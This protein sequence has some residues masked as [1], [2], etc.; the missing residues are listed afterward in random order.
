MRVIWSRFR[1]MRRSLGY[2]L[3]EIHWVYRLLWLLRGVMV[4][5][6]LICLSHPAQEIVFFA[7]DSRALGMK[8]GLGL[9]FLR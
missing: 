5:A 9:V 3:S 7:L 8:D 4:L 6:L 2:R 1:Q